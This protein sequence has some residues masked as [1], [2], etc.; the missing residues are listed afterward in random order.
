MTTR[1]VAF[2]M[3][4]RAGSAAFD[5]RESTSVRLPKEPATGSALIV[6]CPEI[7]Q[8]IETTTVT[9]PGPPFVVQSLGNVVPHECDGSDKTVNSIR[10]GIEASGVRDVI[11]CGHVNCRVIRSVLYQPISGNLCGNESG[12]SGLDSMRELFD[13]LDGEYPESVVREIVI[14]EHLLAQVENLMS[15]RF[16]RDRIQRRSLNLHAWLLDDESETVACYNPT[17]GCF[18]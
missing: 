9:Q 11:I 6:A 17:T 10:H 18:E 15:H 2:P 7:R 14:R 4:T 1:S 16:V 3:I 13:R 5:V 8:C 12:M